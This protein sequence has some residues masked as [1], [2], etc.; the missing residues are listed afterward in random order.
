M[1]TLYYFI[2][3]ENLYRLIFQEE[4][5]F[6]KDAGK[7]RI[8]SNPV[9]HIFSKIDR[10]ARISLNG[11]LLS[12]EYS[13]KETGIDELFEFDCPIN[14]KKYIKHIHLFITENSMEFCQEI[15]K[16]LTV[17][18]V[19]YKRGKVISDCVT[20]LNVEE[21]L[22]EHFKIIKNQLKQKRNLK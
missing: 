13:I 16:K 1:N 19:S 4:P 9:F 21:D 7:I 2:S 12:R 5:F 20:E 3:E 8:S 10:D 6:I 14:I 18:G 11:A 17:M 22:R 15:D